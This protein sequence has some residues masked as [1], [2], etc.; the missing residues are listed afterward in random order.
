MATEIERK[1]LLKDNTWR[2]S[3]ARSEKIIQGYLANTGKSSIRIRISGDHANL[4]LKSMTIGVTRS[5]YDY[6]IPLQDAEYMLKTLCIGPV[7]EKIRHYVEYQGHTWEIDEFS[8]ENRG[9][10]VAEIELEDPH[11]KF[12]EPG[13]LGLEVSDDPRYYN[14]CLAEHPFS[15]WDD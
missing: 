10:I 8:G 13:W 2:N 7:I 14:I 3:V 15:S 12:A 5:E 9:L 1:F 6:L 11:E 4:N